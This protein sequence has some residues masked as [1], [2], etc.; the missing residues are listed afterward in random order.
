MAPTAPCCSSGS[1]LRPEP[2]GGFPLAL[3]LGLSPRLHALIGL[4]HLISAFAA[5]LAGLDVVLLAMLCGVL[6][7]SWWQA[8]GSF[9]PPWRVTLRADGLA[10]IERAGRSLEMR[11][12]PGCL[13]WRRVAWLHLCPLQTGESLATEGRAVRLLVVSDQCSAEAWRLLCLW[14]RQIARDQR[15]RRT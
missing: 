6:V 9:L 2:A 15:E 12:G 8:L 4:P 11:A 13:A 3:R 5:W 10:L 14:L 1:E 7:L